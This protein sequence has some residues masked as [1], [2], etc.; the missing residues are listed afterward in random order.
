MFGGITICLLPLVFVVPTCLAAVEPSLHKPLSG[1]SWS[2][3]HSFSELNVPSEVFL[4]WGNRTFLCHDE[5]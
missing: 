1:K 5:M 2:L 4:G 3:D